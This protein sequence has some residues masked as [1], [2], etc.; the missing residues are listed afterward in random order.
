MSS[1]QCLRWYQLHQP[2]QYRPINFHATIYS[3][4]ACIEILSLSFESHGFCIIYLLVV[5]VDRIWSSLQ[6]RVRD[7][8][9]SSIF[10]SSIIWIIWL[11]SCQLNVF[12]LVLHWYLIIL[13]KEKTSDH[14]LHPYIQ[15]SFLQVFLWKILV[16]CS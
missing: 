9:N 8:W 2:S 10:L 7:L 12:L 6:R 1:I 11:P 4:H 16:Y 3:I 13:D 14:L 15:I 5:S